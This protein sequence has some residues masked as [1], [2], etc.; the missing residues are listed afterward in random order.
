MTLQPL[1]N[2]SEEDIRRYQKN[3]FSIRDTQ[4]RRYNYTSTTDMALT[5]P[6]P[7]KM[8]GNSLR[9]K[10]PTSST[11]Q[12]Y[13]SSNHHELDS[14]VSRHP[15]AEVVVIDAALK[16]DSIRKIPIDFQLR[17]GRCTL[18]GHKEHIH[19]RRLP[20]TFKVLII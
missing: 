11:M 9:W 5:S 3:S 14:I 20:I 10:R 13:T 12:H 19:M 8:N 17:N 7:L 15:R 6:G 2:Q 4:G 1:T 18:E 16:L